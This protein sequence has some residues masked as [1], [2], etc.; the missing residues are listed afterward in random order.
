MNRTREETTRVDCDDD[1]MVV[2]DGT[3]SRVSM[4]LISE[5]ATHYATG[6]IAAALAEVFPP[7]AEAIQSQ[8]G[9]RPESTIP[10]I[11]NA[12]AVGAMKFAVRMIRATESV[13]ERDAEVMMELAIENESREAIDA[14]PEGQF[15]ARSRGRLAYAAHRSGMESLADRWRLG[16]PEDAILPFRVE[17]ACAAIRAKDGPSAIEAVR[18][19]DPKS[20]SAMIEVLDEACA[21]DSAEV[22]ALVVRNLVR[23]RVG[24]DVLIARAQAA[25]SSGAISTFAEIACAIPIICDRAASELPSACM[26]G[27][28][29]LVA[30]IADMCTD[31]DDRAEAIL[32]R[33]LEGGK[34]S[35]FARMCLPLYRIKGGRLSAAVVRDRVL[36]QNFDLRADVLRVLNDAGLIDATP[37]FDGDLIN[38]ATRHPES[39]MWLIDEICPPES[40]ILEMSRVFERAVCVGATETIEALI[41]RPDF[42]F[43]LTELVAAEALGMCA[44][45]GCDAIL[46]Q[47]IALASTE[48]SARFEEF[49][50]IAIE[51]GNAPAA[52]ALIAAHEAK[53]KTPMSFVSAAYSRA[54]GSGSIECSELVAARMS[55][56]DAESGARAIL[57][58]GMFPLADAVRVE[59]MCHL[60]NRF[61]F[62]GSDFAKG[63][64]F[65]IISGLRAVELWKTAEWIDSRLDFWNTGQKS[66]D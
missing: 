19:M 43:T 2:C 17:Y 36:S 6:H 47:I 65:A 5:V 12:L 42:G 20:V 25:L 50:L 35:M 26:R 31:P 62:K 38:S 63:P 13:R 54:L 61:G 10:I 57:D 4:D 40:R 34:V 41:R 59:V 11:G 55:A 16:I 48:I 21:H 44:T 8:S 18:E 64:E 7:A 66:D 3:A 52:R 9:K 51:N 58:D 45:V 30:A 24:D 60:A 39:A 29:C 22:A 23:S 37:P 33:A 56:G 53:T 46:P 1:M 49:A 27:K 32:E 15:T 14:I 28:A